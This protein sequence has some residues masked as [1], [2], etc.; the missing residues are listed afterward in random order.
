[1]KKFWSLLIIATLFFFVR[2][3]EFSK[4]NVDIILS[5][6]EHFK[7]AFCVFE[8][9]A[10]KKILGGISKKIYPAKNKLLT[11]SLGFHEIAEFLH[12]D[13]DC[14][15]HGGKTMIILRMSNYTIM[16]LQKVLLTPIN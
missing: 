6:G 11:T 8:K 9:E 13:A 5:L 3:D 7:V 10:E 1:M 2:N 15:K 14:V 16:G 4:N 12:K